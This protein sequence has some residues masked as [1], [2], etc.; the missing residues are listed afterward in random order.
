MKP[1]PANCR[2]PLNRLEELQCYKLL[3]AIRADDYHL[4]TE[5]TV[6]GVERI[7]DICEPK[8]GIFPLQ[9]AVELNKLA[10]IDTLFKLGAAANTCDLSGK[11]AT[12]AAAE[13][14]LYKAL[15]RLI[16]H[17]AD[18]GL[19]DNNQHDTLCY[20]LTE[21]PEP[22]DMLKCLNLCLEMDEKHYKHS[23]SLLLAI[24]K[25]EPGLSYA[26]EILH[27]MTNPNI[28]NYVNKRTALSYAC[29]FNPT[30]VA[31]LLK[32]GADASQA[33]VKSNSPVHYAAKSGSGAALQALS[34]Y[35]VDF[36]TFNSDGQ[37]PFHT[38]CD[39]DKTKVIKF[40]AQ[41]GSNPKVKDKKGNFGRSL[42]KKKT[43]KDVKKAE[44][45]Y[46]KRP[47]PSQVIF[48]DWLHAFELDIET[49]VPDQVD[50]GE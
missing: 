13:L 25:G 21:G 42:C 22:E 19:V 46:G 39:N 5:L 23:M 17:G 9:L 11:T 26:Q 24:E 40:L 6:E 43:L 30:L 47:E 45:A 14:G 32:K 7:V 1:V 37:N 2:L 10:L 20:C 34:A 33:D 38:A 31:D 44:R 27:H 12:M 18:I 15:D 3:Q 41:R 16:V 48:K 49:F 8:S 35:A 29:E 36:N 4:I 50:C 28:I